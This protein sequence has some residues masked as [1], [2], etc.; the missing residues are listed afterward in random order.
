MEVDTD[1]LSPNSLRNQLSAYQNTVRD[2]HAQSNQNAELLGRLEQMVMDK[3]LEISQLRNVEMEKDLRI[4]AQQRDFQDQLI[5]EQAAL[6]QVT[7]TLEELHQELEAI[8]NE[9]NTQNPM[10]ISSSTD[11]ASA[12][13]H[14][15]QQ[16]EQ[17]NMPSRKNWQK[18]KLNMIKRSRIKIMK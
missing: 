1:Q 2:L 6:Q 11:T 15:K 12:L 9:H 5:A 4:Q 14:L 7:G 3:E 10:D 13:N 17:E 16:V 8:K 18:Q